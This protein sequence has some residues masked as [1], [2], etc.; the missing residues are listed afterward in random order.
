MRSKIKILFTISV[1]TMLLQSASV[2]TAQ[3]TAENSVAVIIDAS[4]SFK[5]RFEEALKRA[6]E[7]LEGMGQTELHRW[8]SGTDQISLISLDALPEVLWKG[9][10]VELK[11]LDATYWEERFSS[12]ADFSGCT[13]VTRAFQLAVDGFKDE[14]HLNKYVF[15]FSDCIDEPPIDSL[16][17]CA[18]PTYPSPPPSEFPWSEL[19]GCSVSVFWIPAEQKFSWHKAIVE[20]NLEN[21]FSL[22]SPSEMTVIAISPP[23][24][25]KIVYS[26]EEKQ[27]VREMTVKTG[28]KIIK[29][30]G[31]ALGCM[32][33]FFLFVMC[34]AFVSRKNKPRIPHAISKGDPQQDK[35]RDTNKHKISHS[36]E[37]NRRPKH[38]PH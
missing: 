5:G 12:R 18:A 33:V 35:R 19:S 8:E 11:A 21:S 31:I 26:E 37:E 6:T 9:S 38:A 16:R 28:I 34:I 1:F 24:R 23:P 10:L 15:A 36:R 14:K 4:G 29:W 32:F 25:S 30:G 27:A 20:R 7:L 13:D 17:S 3:M 22:F 2:T